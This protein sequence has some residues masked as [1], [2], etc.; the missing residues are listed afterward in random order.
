M[1]L[2]TLNLNYDEARH[3]PWPDRRELLVKAIQRSDPDVIALQAVRKPAEDM[4]D[5]DQATQL[6][7]RLPVYSHVTFEP[8]DHGPRGSEN[9][10]ALLSRWPL[11]EVET[12][13]LGARTDSKGKQPQD[14]AQRLVMTAQV[15]GTRMRVFN[16]HY[17]WVY[18]QAVGNLEE[19]LAFMHRFTGEMVL[20]G[21]L[22]TTPDA[23]MMERLVQ[24]GWTDAW[25][26]LRPGDDGYTFESHAPEKRIDYVWVKGGLQD[27]LEAIDVVGAPPNDRGYRL[28]DHLGLLVTFAS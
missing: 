22:N 24:D 6:A 2:L 3:G 18:A 25:R 13:P 12:L 14:A 23:P 4:R 7:R 9:G 15:A 11:I 20:V 19:A 21:D 1:K 8:A 28:S 27:R 10:S 17:S 5:G 26:A 16:S